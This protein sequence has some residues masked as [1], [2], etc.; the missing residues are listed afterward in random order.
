M[1]SN[2]EARSCKLLG[3]DAC[4]SMASQVERF[5]RAGFNGPSQV[6]TMTDYYRNKMLAN[7]RDRIESIEFL[8]ESEL[9]FQLMDHYCICVVTN[10]PDLGDILF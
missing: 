2:M 6:L 1:L 8:D 3:V 4:A 7:E 9:L 5:T 10:N